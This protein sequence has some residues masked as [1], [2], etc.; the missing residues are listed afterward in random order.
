MNS[1][2]LLLLL[3]L[4]T[5]QR[6]PAPPPPVRIPEQPRRPSPA[7]APAPAGRFVEITPLPETIELDVGAT[8]LAQVEVPALLRALATESLIRSSLEADG[9]VPITVTQERP[10]FWPSQ[11]SADWYVVASYSG[12]AQA[13]PMPSAIKRLWLAVA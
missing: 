4:A 13:R 3:Y 8:Y 10:A 9:F 1:L 12:A 2:G 6:P 11:D 5:R 7:P